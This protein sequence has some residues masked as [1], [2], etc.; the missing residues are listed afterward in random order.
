VKTAA[1]FALG[2]TVAA[3]VLVF[4]GYVVL[5]WPVETGP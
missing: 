2:W 4:I 1:R 5:T 3:A